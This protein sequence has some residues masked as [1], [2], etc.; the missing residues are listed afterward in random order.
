[1][2]RFLVQPVPFGEDSTIMKQRAVIGRL[3]G[4]LVDA[5]SRGFAGL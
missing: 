5:Y 2:S 1:M 3:T 4:V